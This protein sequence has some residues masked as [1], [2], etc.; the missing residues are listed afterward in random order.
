MIVIASAVNAGMGDQSPM[1]EASLA[2]TTRI[3]AWTH[4]GAWSAVV[5]IVL[6]TAA[7]LLFLSRH[8][9]VWHRIL[10]KGEA[11]TKHNHMLDLILVSIVLAGFVITRGV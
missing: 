4:F 2:T 6:V 8:A 7:F 11:I 9:L 5:A 1:I 10:V 3:E